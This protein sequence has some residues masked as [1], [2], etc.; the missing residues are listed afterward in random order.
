MRTSYWNDVNLPTNIYFSERDHTVNIATF[1]PRIISY[2]DKFIGEPGVL[3]VVCTSCGA[4]VY[5]FDKDL[6][7]DIFTHERN[8]QYQAHEQAPTPAEDDS[9]KNAAS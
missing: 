5:C 6:F 3:E 8:S 1:E 7:L 9:S 2:L 4:M